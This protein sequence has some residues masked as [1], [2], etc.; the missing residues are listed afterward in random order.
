LIQGCS[1]WVLRTLLQNAAHLLE[2]F[3]SLFW[4]RPWVSTLQE[5]SDGRS[6]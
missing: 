4:T 2:M 6:R 5:V 1:A 3:R